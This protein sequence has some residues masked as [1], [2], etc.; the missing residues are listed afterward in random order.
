MGYLKIE[1]QKVTVNT[2]RQMKLAGEKI[3][4]MTAYDYT[5]AQILDQAGLDS[6]LIGD[7]ASNVMQ[8]NETTLPITLEEMIYHARAVARGAQHSLVVC[9]MPFGSY[10]ASVEEAVGNA[11]RVMKET[12]VDALKLE[13]G[14]SIIDKVKAI[15]AAGIP[16]M[17]HIGLMPQS[18]HQFG[19]YG[20]R[21]KEAVEAKRM[22][23]DALALDAAG[24][25]SMVLEK[26]PANLAEEITQQVKAATIGIGAGNKTD[27][28]V[29]VYADALGMSDGFSPK[30]LRRFADMR[31]CM[32][33]GVME[34]IKSVK[35]SDFPNDAESYF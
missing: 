4:Q 20:V 22:V 15:I 34:Y 10:Q 18:I 27:G 3:A 12:G 30:F 35:S 24:V 29:L 6:I 8:G 33:G 2:I 28:Q 5:T 1:K 16:V 26:I 9:D 17:G 13:G 21:G 31:A 32:T 7:S 25:F 19:D 23:E 14:V 11:I